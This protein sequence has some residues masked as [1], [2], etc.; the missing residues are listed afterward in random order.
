MRL[1][2]VQHNFFANL[3]F[4]NHKFDFVR[5]C[6]VGLGVPGESLSLSRDQVARSFVSA[7]LGP[8]SSQSI[9]GTL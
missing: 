5:I 6:Y 7:D 9:F 4:E 8:R 2:Y 1:S 3:P